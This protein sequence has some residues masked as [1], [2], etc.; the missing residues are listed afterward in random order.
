M[1]YRSISITDVLENFKIDKADFE[2]F[3]E[4]KA[5]RIHSTL[6]QNYPSTVSNL[7]Y[8][9]VRGLEY[10]APEL[11]EYHQ[12]LLK[13]LECSEIKYPLENMDSNEKIAKALFRNN[14]T[15][16]L[17]IKA[18]KNSLINVYSDIQ[19]KLGTIYDTPIIEGLVRFYG[20]LYFDIESMLF[21]KGGRRTVQSP[22]MDIF[23][24]S[25]NIKFN[26][27]PNGIV[28]IA[29]SIILLRQA[30]ETKIHQ[31]F[32]I[33]CFRDQDN[34]ELAVNI[35]YVLSVLNKPKFKR[36][37]K[38]PIDIELLLAI[39]TWSN[40]YIHTGNF[41]APLW[42]I[43]WSHRSIGSLFYGIDCDILALEKS[44][45]VDEDYLNLSMYQELEEAISKKIGDKKI[46]IE[47]M[48]HKLH[49]VKNIPNFLK[50]YPNAWHI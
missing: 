32:G 30:I 43:E 13:K 49:P 4:E 9:Y 8:S 16:A 14:T 34:K 22:D 48:P 33:R 50:K 39:N 29:T 17:H 42:V 40:Y 38:F 6:L 12:R 10:F 45:I 11:N 36:Q 37:I 44:I 1:S 15:T 5:N 7:L 3:Q 20:F 46:I 2:K 18:A 47:K 24:I 25:K 26:L 35:G 28:T 19:N 41:S 21:G 23:Q 31:S 27:I